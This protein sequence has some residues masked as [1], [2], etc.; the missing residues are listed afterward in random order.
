M[1]FNSYYFVLYYLPVLLVGYY[2]LGKHYKPAVAHMWLLAFSVIFCLSH[3]AWQT[4]ILAADIAANY[5][6]SRGISQKSGKNDKV[7]KLLL[8]TA[9]LFNIGVL[10][11]FKYLGFFASVL[12]MFTKKG[13][14]VTILIMPL[15]LSYLAFRMIGYV[16]D[17]YKG[18]QE[19]PSFG[20]FLLYAFY[21]PMI[22]QGPIT[23][24]E[25]FLN[26]LKDENHVKFNSDRFAKG[27]YL[28]AMGL[29]KKMLIADTLAK[30]VTWGFENAGRITSAD[31]ILVIIA[32]TSQLYFD[33][34]GYCDMANGISEMFGITL[35]L[36]FDS[37]YKSKSLSEEWRRWHITLGDFL[38][39]Y[40]Y[41][42][43]GGSKKGTVRTYINI[44]L[45]FTISGFWHGAD[46]TYILWGLASGVIQCF[47]RAFDKGLSKINGVIRCIGTYI[48]WNI[49]V[50]I[51]R[52]E[53]LPQFWYLFSGIFIRHDFSVTHELL[54][55]ATTFEIDYLEEHM[56]ALGEHLSLLHLPVFLLISLIIIFGMKNLYE[57]EFKP[58]VFKA[59][60]VALSLFWCILSMGGMTTFLYA[61]Y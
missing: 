16:A 5:F 17:V 22:V 18:E 47:E 11:A 23:S 42:P 45:V 40:I 33:F 13:Y 35:P 53:S 19:V 1:Y 36:N 57:K 26:A 51:F 41:I 46:F 9:I 38:R 15:G 50:L 4:L 14:S 21:F 10:F 25:L 6:I 8:V 43:L 7:R 48:L 34:S 44:V 3:G 52:S 30:S 31:T 49:T 27:L 28:F 54:Q 20:D 58:G 12:D 2:I 32:Y 39:K 61:V 59:V 37:P 24:S 55:T 60:F 29:L 56:G